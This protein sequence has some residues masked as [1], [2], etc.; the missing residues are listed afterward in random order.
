VKGE[1]PGVRKGEGRWKGVSVRYFLCGDELW[2]D[3]GSGSVSGRVTSRGRGLSGRL[4][5]G[6]SEGGS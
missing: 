2:Q 5:R 4:F 3:A 1:R 6:A